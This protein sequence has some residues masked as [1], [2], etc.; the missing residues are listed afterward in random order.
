MVSVLV[1]LLI[2]MNEEHIFGSL[3]CIEFLN[4]EVLKEKSAINYVFH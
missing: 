3:F 1:Y 2:K 4:K